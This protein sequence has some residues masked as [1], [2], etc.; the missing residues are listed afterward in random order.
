MEKNLSQQALP[1]QIA[2]G[3]SGAGPGNASPTW[4]YPV[5]INAMKYVQNNSFVLYLRFNASLEWEIG[6][7]E[8]APPLRTSLFGIYI[9]MLNVHAY[10]A[11]IN[12]M[13]L[14]NK[15]I[16]DEVTETALIAL[17]KDFINT[18]DLLPIK[19]YQLLLQRITNDY[20]K[21][22]A[23]YPSEIFAGMMLPT[24][25][26]IRMYL[27]TP[28]LIAEGY[29]L[30]IENAPFPEQPITL[31]NLA[32]CGFIRLQIATTYRERVEASIADFETWYNFVS[33]RHLASILS[34]QYKQTVIR[35]RNT[36]VASG[37]PGNALVVG[38]SDG[39]EL[40]RFVA[41]LG[42]HGK[43]MTNASMYVLLTTAAVVGHLK[44]NYSRA[45]WLRIYRIDT[46]AMIKPVKES[47]QTVIN[48]IIFEAREYETLYKELTKK[49]T[50][51]LFDT[52]MIRTL[53]NLQ[54]Q[55]DTFGYVL[56]RRAKDFKYPIVDIEVKRTRKNLA[57]RVN[58]F[59]M[60]KRLL[61]MRLG[62][63]RDHLDRLMGVGMKI[64]EDMKAEDIDNQTFEDLMLLNE[65]L[66][67][68]ADDIPADKSNIEELAM[69]VP[70]VP[71]EDLA[72]IASMEGQAN[73]EGS[74]YMAPDIEQMAN[75]VVPEIKEEQKMVIPIPEIE[76]AIVASAPPMPEISGIQETI[77]P[78]VPME[79][80]GLDAPIEIAYLPIVEEVK[81]EIKEI[82]P[83]TQLKAP[84]ANIVTEIK[85]IAA[86]EK[87]QE[88]PKLINIMP[89]P[90]K[91][92]AHAIETMSAPALF[93]TKA[94]LDIIR[95]DKPALN[96]AVERRL[97]IEKLK[98]TAKMQ[99]E[100]KTK[101]RVSK[102]M[103]E[104]EF[105]IIEKDLKGK[106]NVISDIKA[107][108]ASGMTLSKAEKK[109]VYFDN[110]M[111]I[112]YNQDI[113]KTKKSLLSSLIQKRLKTLL[114]FDNK[115]DPEMYKIPP[116][117]EWADIRA[118]AK[119]PALYELI[120]F[121]RINILHMDDEYRKEICS[122]WA[123]IV[124]KE[125]MPLVEQHVVEFVYYATDAFDIKVGNG[126]YK[127]V[128]ISATDTSEEIIKKID[129]AM[130][131]LC[132]AVLYDT[133]ISGSGNTEIE[134]LLPDDRKKYNAEKEIISGDKANVFVQY[135]RLQRPVKEL[136]LK[137]PIKAFSSSL[138]KPHSAVRE[139]IKYST[140]TNVGICIFE[141]YQIII[142][143]GYNSKKRI[144]SEEKWC[145]DIIG[146]LIERYPNF[147]G[148]CQDGDAK[149]FLNQMYLLTN[150]NIALFNFYTNDIWAPNFSIACEENVMLY[151]ANH[152]HVTSIAILLKHYGL[153][154]KY[155]GTNLYALLASVKQRKNKKKFRE[156]Q[157]NSM[158]P[159]KHLKSAT[160]E[161]KAPTIKP[162]KHVHWGLDYETYTVGI[163]GEQQPYLL[164]VVKVSNSGEDQEKTERHVY[165][166]EKCTLDFIFEI[167]MPILA[168]KDG[169]IQHHFWTYN[170][171]NFDFHF[172][173]CALQKLFSVKI[174]GSSTSFKSL[175]VGKNIS[176]LDLACWYNMPYNKDLECNGL[177]ALAKVC[178]TKHQKG[179]FGY[180]VKADDL[181][182]EEFKK[183]AIE[184]CV[185]D[186][187]VL[188]DLVNML[189]IDL[190]EKFQFMGKK[191]CTDKAKFY[192]HSAASLALTIY[193]NCFM[194]PLT[195]LKSSKSKMYKLERE[196]Y[197][198]G[199]TIPFRTMAILVK[200][201]DINSSYPYVMLNHEMPYRYLNSEQYKSGLLY[202]RDKC[203]KFNDHDLIEYYAFEFPTK[204]FLPCLM[205][206]SP[207]GSLIQ[208]LK[209]DSGDKT[210]SAWG[211]EIRLALQQ[212]AK[213]WVK[214]RHI[215]EGKIVFSNYVKHFYEAKK[216]AKKDK[217]SAAELF[218]K[219]LLNSLQGKL[220]EKERENKT[221][222]Q[223]H[224]VANAIFAQG[225]EN[226]KGVEYLNNGIY[227]ATWRLEKDEE[228]SRIGSLVRFP[229]YIAAAAR[230]NLIKAMLS[231]PSKYIVYCDTDSIF[232][233]N[234]YS[235]PKDFLSD[236]ELGKFKEEKDKE[237]DI[238]LCF[239]AKNYALLKGTKAQ[240][241]CKGIRPPEN[242]VGYI[243]KL[244]NDEEIRSNIKPFFKKS[245]GTIYITSCERC[246]RNTVCFKRA[247]ASGYYTLP[248]RDLVEYAEIYKQNE[249][250]GK[251]KKIDK[252]T[253]ISRKNEREIMLSRLAAVAYETSSH[254]TLEVIADKL[255]SSLICLPEESNK[256][257]IKKAIELH[258]KDVEMKKELLLSAAI[259]DPEMLVK[260]KNEILNTHQEL[261]QTIDKIIALGKNKDEKEMKEHEDLLDYLL[262]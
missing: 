152:V 64:V 137:M 79:E 185:L 26:L 17:L 187:Y 130:R 233:S 58:D 215:Y 83:M 31:D 260:L 255:K 214:A 241:K 145:E 91:L 160:K 81:E 80:P 230:I 149:E 246:I 116:M 181:Q 237:S 128:T 123:E 234:G 127:P 144:D 78:Q 121:P 184:Y 61:K 179:N 34:P 60:A 65:T 48:Q 243:D 70:E 157:L 238:M 5:G 50:D 217:N 82:P 183:K 89:Q 216:M 142:H 52:A 251:V 74:I 156:Y 141:A 205:V 28:E 242:I 45:D 203:P 223:L 55:N 199:I 228:L 249:S 202:E 122:L 133:T 75:S 119:G 9:E 222:G 13:M 6:R 190:Y 1:V 210:M 102:I 73:D 2:E 188:N 3:A 92:V 186:V 15:E 109:W 207:N 16:D 161:R 253:I 103:R 250:K 112:T 151:Y 69:E 163:H 204:T 212:G 258:L 49:R 148:I 194:G 227:R 189:V 93:E 143:N 168:D 56:T 259:N 221:I 192:P 206:K 209:H 101:K 231:V 196:S 224:V 43:E 110:L 261:D 193:K 57:G 180:D 86:K 62:T 131:E 154:T 27:P 211:Y 257:Y 113:R 153:E 191:A 139:L 129:A 164:A 7:Y 200:C 94:A 90:P 66:G 63:I 53:N 138:I 262:K 155:D 100:Q 208:V 24:T 178:K 120:E 40:I 51:Q 175:K 135:I 118:I 219:N 77:I 240:L 25:D 68:A 98:T 140:R 115:K 30:V 252:E 167:L 197:H 245:Y 35:Q 76:S 225:T 239:G 46:I 248:F 47:I 247:N 105:R 254:G 19:G 87:K 236:D 33:T 42:T 174:L 37:D 201:F 218:N 14:K 132:E 8:L 39:R 126:G 147:I 134:L 195:N 29:R 150:K 104:K 108:R 125:F 84:E 96:K 226:L 166:G 170:G 54:D 162:V 159:D 71:A 99:E 36:L 18:E 182:N 59:V 256:E 21:H 67:L 177:R 97:E 136:A 85:S 111:R 4:T 232:L 114:E 11:L 23:I 235:L 213:I 229:S 173:I 41:Q 22:G 165:W 12:A 171:A 95:V 220:G 169:S 244:V 32:V 38:T 10:T 198:G 44:V 124:M 158:I 72:N 176:F 20:K 107:K 146:L 117:G 106:R 88:E 172:L